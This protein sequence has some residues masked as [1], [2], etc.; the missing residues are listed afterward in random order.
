MY[1]AVKVM[2]EEVIEKMVK[3]PR[4]EQYKIIKYNNNKTFVF[5]L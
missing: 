5:I 1:S 2:C 3:V 4:Q